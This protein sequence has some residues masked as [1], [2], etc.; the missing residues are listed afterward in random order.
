MVKLTY[1]FCVVMIA[2]NIVR[3]SIVTC[4]LLQHNIGPVQFLIRLTVDLS[5]LP[6]SVKLIG[7]VPVSISHVTDTVTEFITH[8]RLDSRIDE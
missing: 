7:N 3:Y 4:Y 2:V 6:D 8:L 1:A 5:K